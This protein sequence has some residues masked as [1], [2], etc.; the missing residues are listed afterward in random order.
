MHPSRLPMSSAD[1]EPIL[2][3]ENLRAYYTSK[4]GLVRAVEDVSFTVM[5]GESVGLFGESGAGKT[6][7]ALAIMGVF[8]K[9][10]RYYASSSGDESTKKLWEL[11]DEARRKGLT[12]AE[13]AQALPG[14]EGQI[15][16]KGKNLL[17]LDEKEYRK[18]RG[19]EI[20]YVPQGSRKSMNPYMTIDYQTAESLWAHD[21]DR[22]LHERQVMRRVLEVLDLIELSDVDIRKAFKP[23]QFSM[24]EDQRILIAMAMI[25]RPA[26]MIADEPTTGMDSG[27]RHRVLEAIELVRKELKTSMLFI[28]N[29]QKVMADLVDRVAVMSA[30]RIMEFGDAK[31]VLKSPGHPFT[32]AFI[33]SNPTMEVLRRIREKGLVIRGIPG[34]PPDMS[35]PPPGCPF[36]PRCEYATSLCKQRVPDYREVEPGHWI[37]CHRYEELP[38]F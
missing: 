9:V 5:K 30:G 21:E 25:T 23:G 11:R 4:K 13:M 34:S 36:N 7:V 18:I 28:S 38:K 20:T 37:L 6:S 24:G 3:I 31:T 35:N 32:R 14:V 26:L 15:W 2:R 19:N 27:V 12:S 16:F 17:K 22:A 8:D 33:M 1:N 29:D 10:S